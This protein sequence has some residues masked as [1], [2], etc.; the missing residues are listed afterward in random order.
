MERSHSFICD[1]HT[2]CV[3][4]L[5]VAYGCNH[6]GASL[7]SA[8]IASS[9]AAKHAAFAA[10]TYNVRK[11]SR[12]HVSCLSVCLSACICVPGKARTRHGQ[13]RGTGTV[14]LLTD[15]FATDTQTQHASNAI[16]KTQRATTTTTQQQLVV[17]WMYVSVV[18]SS[19]PTCP[20]TSTCPMS[21]RDS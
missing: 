3:C 7:L 21:V 11:L 10:Q 5:F 17:K 16:A 12:G 14:A 8:R 20:C 18:T 19:S 9:Y 4:R 2:S 13:F 6:Y 15:N 1:A